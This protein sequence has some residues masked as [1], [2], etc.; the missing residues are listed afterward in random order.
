MEEPSLSFQ[1]GDR[2]PRAEFSG[3][4]GD[5]YQGKPE[6]EGFVCETERAY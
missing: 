2:P 1:E 3:R 5:G 4:E 6:L